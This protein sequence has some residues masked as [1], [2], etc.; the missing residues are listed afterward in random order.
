MTIAL[1][2]KH[3]ILRTGLVFFIKDHFTE[4]TILES[5]S[6][7]T[8]YESYRD[9][10]P[11]LII[12][13]ISQ[14]SNSNNLNFINLV[15]KKYPKAAI[16]LYDEK[17]GT[18]MGFH[19]LKAGVKGYLSKQNNLTELI[20]CITDVLKGKRYICNDV[21]EIILDGNFVE[22]IDSQEENISLTSREYEIA[23]YLSQ[24]MK[25][26]LIAQTLGRKMSTISTIKTNIFKKLEVDNI[27]KLR[28]VLLP[29][30]SVSMR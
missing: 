27:L 11:D 2:D 14:D 3:P 23:Q 21:L 6:I 19:Y 12:L 28:E 4:A 8:F 5:D 13:G 10:K 25:T 24:G 26:S 22:K 20:D 1:I 29:K 15:K 18:S 17:P 30:S 16:V 9:Q 7:V